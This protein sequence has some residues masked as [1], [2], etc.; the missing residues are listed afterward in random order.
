M[1][2]YLSANLDPAYENDRPPAFDFNDMV[3]ANETSTDDDVNT[4]DN[5]KKQVFRKSSISRGSF[6]IDCYRRWPS[7][8][9]RQC[10]P[11]SSPS[12]LQARSD[13]FVD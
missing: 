5:A 6:L 7:L 12:L 1:E 8:M 3:G 9:S 4:N 10:L 13:R 11:T 2:T